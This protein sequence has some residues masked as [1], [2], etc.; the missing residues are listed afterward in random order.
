MKD[1]P[2]VIQFPEVREVQPRVR[3]VSQRRRERVVRALRSWRARQED[4]DDIN[5]AVSEAEWKSDVR[6]PL[7]RPERLDVTGHADDASLPQR[8]V[9]TFRA[10]IFKTLFRFGIWLWAALRFGVGNLRDVMR[11]K[12][13]EQ[14]RAIRLRK[15]FQRAG[16]TF[17]KLG[18]QLSV[19]MDLV[20]YTYAREL[21]KLLDN[22]PAF[23]SKQAIATIEST[24]HRKLGDIF[25]VFDPVPIGSASVACVY[26][27]V[28]H[29]GRRVAVKVRRP[30]IGE[31]LVA[32]MRALL[33]LLRALELV[34][35]PPGFTRHFTYELRTM[36]LEELDFVQEARLT[37]L[38][39]KRVKK[40][41]LS[42][43]T[44]PCVHFDYCG[45]EVIVTDF[46]AG[47]WATDLLRAVEGNDLATLQKLREQGIDP[48]RVARNYMQVNRFGG[49]ENIFFHA[50]LHPANVLIEE[51]SKLVLIDFGACGAFT[52]AELVSWRRLLDAQAQ[53]DIT[54]MVHAAISLVEPLPAIDVDEFQA[55]LEQV[56]WKDLYAIKSKHSPWWEHTSATIWISFLKLAREY[57]IPMNLNTLRMIRVSM[58]ADTVA[59]RLDHDIDPYAEYRRYE[60]GAGKRAHKRLRKW[61]RRETGPRLF[62][63]VEQ[64]AHTVG[65]TLF[66]FQRFIEGSPLLNFANEIGKAAYAFKLLIG[67]GSAAV[68]ATFTV[69]LAQAAWLKLHHQDAHPIPL[70]IA[71]VTNGWY[72]AALM[73]GAVLVIRRLN[74]KMGRV[75]VD[76]NRRQY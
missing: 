7:R 19:R 17:I 64:F 49:F 41:K 26:Q 2:N 11:G 75:E 51:G 25:A 72:V 56:F 60:K 15:T 71:L 39:R 57:R 66:K 28:L 35:L 73:A 68:S 48:K 46:V 21:E 44:A 31:D 14:R 69:V 62:S 37:D 43:V 10:G 33:W 30:H 6:V 22:V 36:L 12:A 42:Y 24:L 38:F 59:A 5:V 3:T 50:D 45:N 16:P 63:R 40:A 9:E 55:R 54:G 13:S 29:N 32:D 67:V 1:E 70:L 23:P 4:A 8:R 61:A 47:V 65:A 74:Y 34:W 27:A 20:P 18:Q 58:L 52:R 53:E 76:D